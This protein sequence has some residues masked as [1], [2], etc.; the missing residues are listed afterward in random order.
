METLKQQT[1]QEKNKEHLR[2]YHREWRKKNPEKSRA[3]K[4]RY[5]IKRKDERKRISDKKTKRKIK[6]EEMYF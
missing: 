2:E 4:Q 3:I 5:E 6:K 1:W